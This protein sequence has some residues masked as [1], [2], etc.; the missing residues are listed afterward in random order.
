MQ[1][2]L[3]DE[4]EDPREALDLAHARQV[5]LQATSRRAVLDVVTARK[6][7]ELQARQLQP[8][9]SRLDERARAA[10]QEG[11]RDAARDAMTRRVALAGEL[12]ELAQQAAALAAEES[13]LREVAAHVEARVEQLRVR[14]EALRA[15]RA[16]ATARA[17]VGRLLEEARASDVE[18]RLALQEAE[19]R[20][21]PA[22]ALPAPPP[23]DEELT[24]ME[25][26]LLWG[27][28][29]QPSSSEGGSE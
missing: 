3:L 19:R 24:R 9:V 22:P 2:G 12:E 21:A 15:G 4:A 7:L 16:A 1:L 13:R 29:P 11:R 23:S 28:P 8:T 17:D 27:P 6:R 20:A 14:R 25:E 10:L 5:E 26:E 18:V